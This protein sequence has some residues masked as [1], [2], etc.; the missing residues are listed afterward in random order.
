MNNTL[1]R[2]IRRFF[3]GTFFIG[4]FFIALLCIACTYLF[5]ISI[6]PVSEGL[7]WAAFPISFI[8]GA[9][10]TL[11]FF[12]TQ[13]KASR[14]YLLYLWVAFF[15]PFLIPIIVGLSLHFF[16][17]NWYSVIDPIIGAYALLF[18]PCAIFGIVQL[19]WAVECLPEIHK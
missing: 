17:L 19:L 8:P 4:T 9:I 18:L 3:I 13:K 2:A 12:I 16:Y 7:F 10:T 14:Y 1:Q 6:D 15:T 5:E 11:V